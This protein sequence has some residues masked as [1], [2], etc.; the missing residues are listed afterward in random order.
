MTI[1][2]DLV[3]IFIFSVTANRISNKR[4]REVPSGYH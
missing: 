3:F 1:Q 2:A 4:A